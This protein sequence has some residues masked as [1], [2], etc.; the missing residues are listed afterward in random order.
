MH[1]GGHTV[2]QRFGAAIL[3]CAGLRLTADEKRL[4]ARARPFGAIVFNR[5]L[6][7]PE[8][9]RALCSD[10]RDAAGHDAPI[11]IDQEGGRVQRLRP[12]LASEWAPPLQDVQRMGQNAPRGMYLRYRIIAEELLALGIDGNCAPTLDI[13]R[14]ETHPFLRNRCYGHSLATVVAVGRA[15]AQ[16]HLDAGVLPVIK[17]IP[18]HGLA[19]ADSHTGLP[20]ISAPRST[21]ETQDFAVFRSFSDMPLGMTAHLVFRAYDDKPATL[22]TRMMSYIRQAIGFDGLVMTDDISM[23]A[24]SG[25]VTQRGLAALAA[26]CD[27]VLHCNGDLNEMLDLMEQIGPMT[28]A[29]QARAQAALDQRAALRAAASPIDI[30][31]LR[32]EFAALPSGPDHA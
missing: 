10:I 19:L 21:L 13:A 17:H 25:T 15:V 28:P 24:L 7:T 11:F 3:G 23:Q 9:I 22:S 31:A 12:P 2:T 1:P 29:A 18:G 27:C 26:G 8:Q 30:A 4:F 32:A 16:A 20:V 6:E 5:N 14:D